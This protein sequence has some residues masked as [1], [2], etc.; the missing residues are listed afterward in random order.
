[1]NATTECTKPPMQRWIE[2][3]ISTGKFCELVNVPRH[4][5]EDFILHPVFLLKEKLRGVELAMRELRQ[6][7][8][9]EPYQLDAYISATFIPS[10]REALECQFPGYVHI[11]PRQAAIRENTTQD[12]FRPNPRVAGDASPSCSSLGGDTKPESLTTATVEK[13]FVVLYAGSI[14]VAFHHNH[15]GHVFE[16]VPMVLATRFETEHAATMAAVRA[17]IQRFTVRDLNHE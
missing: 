2:D 1:M 4:V 11:T 9:L 10:M 6:L 17:R 7:L 14:P 3:E 16:P 8:P 5:G 13:P 12:T 15:C